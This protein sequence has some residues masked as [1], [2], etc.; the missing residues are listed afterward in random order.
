MGAVC[1]LDLCRHV[2]FSPLQVNVTLRC[3]SKGTAVVLALVRARSDAVVGRTGVPVVWLC[4][5]ML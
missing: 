3:S 5:C 4:Y 2:S 1:Y